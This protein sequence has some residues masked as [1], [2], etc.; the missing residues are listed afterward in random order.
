MLIIVETFKHWRHYLKNVQH[1][2]LVFT[3]HHNLKKFMKTTKFS[4][5]QIR[6][7]QKLFKYNFRIDYRQNKK[8]STNALFRRSNLMQKNDDVFEKNRRILHRF[9]KFLQLRN[10]NIKIM[11]IACKFQKKIERSN[12]F[13]IHAKSITNQQKTDWRTLMIDETYVIER[14]DELIAIRNV[15]ISKQIYDEKIAKFFVDLIFQILFQNSFVVSF[16]KRLAIFNENDERWIDENDVFRF[17]KK[18]YV[19]ERI[20]F[21]VL[22]RCH[23]DFFANHFEMN[24]ILKLFRR[25]YYWFDRNHDFDM[26]VDMFE[27]VKKYCENCAICKRNKTSKHKSYEKFQFFFV[28]QYRW[29]DFTMNFVTKLSTNKNWNDVKYDNIFVVVD[30][31]TKMIHYIFVTKTIK[32]K[33]LT[34][35]FIRKIIRYHDFFSFI[36]IDRESL[37]TFE[38]Y[39]FL[40]YALKKKTFTMLLTCLTNRF[41]K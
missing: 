1:E 31:F 17:E 38:Y 28:F 24:K 22:Q 8:N 25:K 37:F 29:I 6:W 3:N 39:S 14:F 21:D 30:R 15:M 33:N 18:L 27:F 13:E 2:I 32:I 36:I 7:I 9:Q 20:R 35:M 10:S 16:R 41:N 23:D 26:L 11:L 34:K 19:L 40:C 5:R 4:S 12:F